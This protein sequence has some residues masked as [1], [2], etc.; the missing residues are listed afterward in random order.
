MASRKSGSAAGDKAAAKLTAK[1]ALL[2]KVR[3]SKVHGQGVFAR[4]RIRKGTRIIE[5]VGD[6]ISHARA[7]RRYDDHDANDNHTFLFAVD[8]NVV[9]DATVDG[10]D[11]RF[12]N[13]SCDPNC[14]SNIEN[15][16]V[17]IDAIRTIEPGEELSYDYQIGREPDDPPDVDVIYACRCGADT[18]R[19]TM[20]WPARRPVPRRKKTAGRAGRSSP[21]RRP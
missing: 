10:N 9:I 11:S 18:C 6:R 12:I 1:A 3:K 21:R 2:I 15:R 8:R 5:Y 13:H 19:G 20:L 14:E 16:R 7:N 17:F 4:R